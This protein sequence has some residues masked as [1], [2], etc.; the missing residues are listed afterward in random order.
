[1]A[2]TLTAAIMRCQG[3]VLNDC[4]I[5]APDEPLVGGEPARP[6]DGRDLRRV[7]RGGGSDHHHSDTLANAHREE[8]I[9]LV[10][11]RRQVTPGELLD[12]PDPVPHRVDVHVHP[13]RADVPRTR[14]GQE[15]APGGKALG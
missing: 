11:E 8:E 3:L 13:G 14:A 12:P 4:R 1:M 15:L 5:L 2:E 7:R 9:Y 6:L 10:I